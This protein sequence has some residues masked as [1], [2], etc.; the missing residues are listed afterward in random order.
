MPS[1]DKSPKSAKTNGEGPKAVSFVGKKPGTTKGPEVNTPCQRGKDLKTKGQSCDSRRA[2][3]T[4]PRPGGKV[5]SFECV[6]C[7]HTWTV[8]MGGSF[9]G[10]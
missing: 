5:A 1:K 8:A 3:N 2:Y 6:K 10:P 9:A 7:H 4:S